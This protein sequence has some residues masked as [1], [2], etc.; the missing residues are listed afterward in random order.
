MKYPTSIMKQTSLLFALSMVVLFACSTDGDTDKDM[1]RPTI[2]D[3]GLAEQGLVANPIDCQ[4]YQRGDTIHFCY[5]FT[6]DTELGNFNIEIHNN[7]DH[8]THGTSASECDHDD[9]HEADAELLRRL[10][11]E[12]K[13]D[14]LWVYNRDFA[15]P[16]GQCSYVARVDIPVPADKM[17]GHYHFAIRV[18]DRAGWQ[19]L[20]AIDLEV[21]Q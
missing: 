11:A 5:A 15:I 2:T 16:A 10:Q 13:T 12:G 6:D 8:H 18:T 4:V 19:E 14:T 20:K 1:T 21:S 9:D 7:F 3:Q 17:P